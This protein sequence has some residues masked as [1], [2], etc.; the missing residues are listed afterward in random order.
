[1]QRLFFALWPDPALRERLMGLQQCLTPGVG[2]R[3]DAEN[4]HITL[5]FLGA[6]PVERLHCIEQQL[7][8]IAAPTFNMQLDQLGYWRKPQVLWAGSTQIPLPLSVLV[9]QLR[10]VAVRCGCKVDTRP[11][12]IHLTLYRKVRKTPSDMPGMAPIDWPVNGFALVESITAASGVC[13]RVIRQWLPSADGL[14][15]TSG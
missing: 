10:D 14:D 2:R 3:V 13:Y 9:Q 7:V 8:A 6:T 11:F 12:Q 15:S 4:L 5:L 1:V